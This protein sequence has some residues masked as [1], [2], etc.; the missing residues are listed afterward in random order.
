MTDPKYTSY[1]EWL[2]AWRTTYLEKR[3]YNGWMIPYMDDYFREFS[4]YVKKT[5]PLMRWQVD[6]MT[7]EERKKWG[8]VIWSGQFRSGS[9]AVRAN[10]KMLTKYVKRA[11]ADAR[12]DRKNGGWTGWPSYLTAPDGSKRASNGMWHSEIAGAWDY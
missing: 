7:P 6:M 1:D 3:T 9:H 5:K 11:K 8:L 2:E 4:S 10:Q 12:Q